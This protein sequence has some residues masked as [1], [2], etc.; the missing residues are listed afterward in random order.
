MYFLGVPVNLPTINVSNGSERPIYLRS[1]K[2]LIIHVEILHRL[3][4]I[5]FSFEGY[6]ETEQRFENNTLMYFERQTLMYF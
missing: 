5:R 2:A 3:S 1:L 4:G 6:N